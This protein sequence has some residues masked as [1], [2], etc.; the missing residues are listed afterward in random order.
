M[1]LKDQEEA[2]N[3]MQPQRRPV[4]RIYPTAGVALTHEV[5]SSSWT[6]RMKGGFGDWTCWHVCRAFN[7]DD[8]GYGLYV[9]DEAAVIEADVSHIHS[10]GHPNGKP[11]ASKSSRWPRRPNQFCAQDRRHDDRRLTIDTEDG[12]AIYPKG[13]TTQA[14]QIFFT[15]HERPMMTQY[16]VCKAME[17]SSWTR[18]R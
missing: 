17:D 14:K 3:R 18:H 4:R 11:V 15:V 2:G 10:T 16:S 1:K 8:E 12:N 13:G 7:H 9:I 5:H 6:P